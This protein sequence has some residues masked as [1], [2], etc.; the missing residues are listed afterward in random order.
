VHFPSESAANGEEQEVIRKDTLHLL[1]EK[2]WTEAVRKVRKASEEFSK[3]RTLVDIVFNAVQIITEAVGAVT[4]CG[5]DIDNYASTDTTKAKVRDRLHRQ[6]A[7]DRVAVSVL[8]QTLPRRHDRGTLTGAVLE[9]ARAVN[10][11][12]IDDLLGWTR[13]K[14]VDRGSLKGVL[15][16]MCE[17]GTLKKVR[18]GQKGRQK[19]K[20]IYTI[21]DSI[22]NKV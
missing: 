17:R 15:N 2:E 5:V 16:H 21:N 6:A 19:G 8:R 3:S 10:R 12:T 18:H 20:A 11:F 9:F 14:D 1:T 22:A 13:L 7:I 4:H